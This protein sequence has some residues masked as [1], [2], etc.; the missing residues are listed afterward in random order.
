MSESEKESPGTTIQM[1]GSLVDDAIVSLAFSHVSAA[2]SAYA[3]A[4]ALEI[5]LLE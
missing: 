4:G 5:G 2:T 3:F 1:T